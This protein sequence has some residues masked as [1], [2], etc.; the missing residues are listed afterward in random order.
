VLS[1][2]RV[3]LFVFLSILLPPP[4]STLFPYTTLFR[5]MIL[6]L[7]CD[8]PAPS[9]RI[10]V[11]RHGNPVVRYALTADTMDGL[12]RGTRAAARIFFAAGASR[13][14]APADPPLIEAHEAGRLDERISA[15]YFLPGTLAIT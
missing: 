9:N 2:H 14:H 13:V 7:A 10:T 3:F 5:S 12:V 15:R 1:R 11:D 4:R 8:H 6:I